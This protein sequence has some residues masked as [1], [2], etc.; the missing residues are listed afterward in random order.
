VPER[1]RRDGDHLVLTLY[2]AEVETL[3]D[4]GRQL[5]SL[6]VEPG[7][8]APD[9]ERGQDPVRDRLFP[10]AYLDPTAD[11]EES[12]WQSTVH[13]D[14]VRQKSEAVEALIASLDV[15][16]PTGDR[17]LELVLDG[18]T[19]E[20]WAAALNDV[21]LALGVVLEITDEEILVP[22][23]DPR[24]PGLELYQWLTMMQGVLIDTLLGG[25][26]EI[27]QAAQDY[28]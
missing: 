15:D 28:R 2:P 5:E 20:Q 14:L 24:A 27:W 22:P 17:Y 13:G 10:R 11:Q 26:D 4:L 19:A 21:R 16:L 9:P 3:R 23:G 25:S 12:D 1:I 7:D 6:L 18:A 8:D